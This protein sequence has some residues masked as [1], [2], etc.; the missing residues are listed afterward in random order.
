MAAAKQG[1]LVVG[2]P[3]I[4]AQLAAKIP[5]TVVFS[6]KDRG[7]DLSAHLDETQR[8]GQLHRVDVD[9]LAPGVWTEVHNRMAEVI[10]LPGIDPL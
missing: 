2:P 5:A 7:M 9:V 10:G 1:V 4:A 8:R 3:E 6:L